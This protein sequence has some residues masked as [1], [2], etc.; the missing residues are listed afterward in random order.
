VLAGALI[1]LFL[2]RRGVVLTPLCAAA[3]G[4]IIA[5]TAGLAPHG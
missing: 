5:P 4:V 2:L 3:T 1:V